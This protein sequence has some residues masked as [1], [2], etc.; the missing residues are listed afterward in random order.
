MRKVTSKRTVSRC[1]GSSTVDGKKLKHKTF[2]VGST[3]ADYD[4]ISYCCNGKTEKKSTESEDESNSPPPGIGFSFDA[5]HQ[6][7]YH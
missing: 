7:L 4:S 5:Y 2:V 6:P 3:T 1:K